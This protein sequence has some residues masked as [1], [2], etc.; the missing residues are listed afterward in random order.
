AATIRTRFR[1]EKMMIEFMASPTDATREVCSPPPCGEGLGVGVVVVDA[2]HAPTTT[3]L[4]SPPP[5][6]LGYTRV[7]HFLS[8]RNRI[9][10]TSAGEGAPLPSCTNVPLISLGTL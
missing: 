6:E 9:H 1:R 4:P 10:P 8:G 5:P 3:P 2:P 7:R